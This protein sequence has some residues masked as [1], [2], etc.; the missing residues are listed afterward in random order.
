MMPIIANILLAPGSLISTRCA[1]GTTHRGCSERSLYPL[2]QGPDC[3]ACLRSGVANRDWQRSPLSPPLDRVIGQ[4]TA[5][6]LA[7]GVKRLLVAFVEDDQELAVRPT[8][9]KI[10]FPKRALERAGNHTQ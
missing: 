7:H 1:E 2:H 9:D 3:V 10:C 5:Y 6:S 4:Q 8:A